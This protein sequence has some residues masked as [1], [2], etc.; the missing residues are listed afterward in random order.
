MSPQNLTRPEHRVCR[1]HTESPLVKKKT[2]S[3]MRT[4]K[5]VLTCLLHLNNNPSQ[6]MRSIIRALCMCRIGHL[7]SSINS[8]LQGFQFSCILVWTTYLQSL[9]GLISQLKWYFN[10]GLSKRI[11]TKVK[12]SP[13]WSITGFVLQTKQKLGKGLAFQIQSFTPRT[14]GVLPY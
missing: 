12:R 3:G 5:S 7:T 11:T 14:R 13:N 9:V 4:W 8:S 6:T 2:K 10:L 1:K